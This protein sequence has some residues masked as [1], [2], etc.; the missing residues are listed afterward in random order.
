MTS[1]FDSLHRLERLTSQ[2]N[3]PLGQN[4]FHSL[5]ERMNQSYSTMSLQGLGGIN[6]IAKSIAKH[7][8]PIDKGSLAAISSIGANV[9][10]LIGQQN[11]TSP[12]AFGNLSTHLSSIYNHNPKLSNTIAGMASSQ[13]FLTRNLEQIAK[14]VE[15]SHLNNF[16]SLNVAIQGISTS[17]LQESIKTR[18]WDEIGVVEEV[19]ETISNASEVLIESPDYITKEDFKNF[20]I[21]IIAS[22]TD[23]SIKSRSEKTKS[24]LRDLMAVISLIIGIYGGY[25][26]LTDQLSQEN[27]NTTP[28]ELE[29]F[30]KDI[31][32]KIK[33]EYMVS[34]QSR[35]STTNVNLRYSNNKRSKWLGLIKKGQQVTV[36]E[37]RHKWLLISFVDF[38]TG[39]PKSGF[40]MKK[41]FDVVKE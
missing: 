39:E 9:S 10:K 38:E 12:F 8:K 1:I 7:M 14:S 17:F 15:N 25:H 4:S 19:N 3:S 6:E 34:L 23:L 18:N 37:N 35:I 27:R 26:L 2:F 36:I 13:L 22:L 24:F 29:K 21:S 11:V 16:N 30:K 33:N 41:Y 32:E 20:G 40:V 5:Y 31:I 28:I